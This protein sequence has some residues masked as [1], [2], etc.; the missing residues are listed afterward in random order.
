[1][2]GAMHTAMAAVAEADPDSINASKKLYNLSLQPIKE[3]NA[4]KTQIKLF[5]EANTLPYVE[6]GVRLLNRD[7]LQ[8][9]NE[10]MQELQGM[11]HE[12]AA[13]VQQWREPILQDAMTRLNKAYN[14]ANYPQDLSTLFSVEWSFPSVEPPSYLEK[15]CPALYE[16]EKQRV[17]ARFDEAVNLAEQAFLHELQQLVNTL[18]ERLTP[19]PDGKRKIIT[20]SAVQNLTDFFTKFQK[21]NLTNNQELET[22]VAEAKAAHRRRERRR[23]EK[24][25]RA[26]QRDRPG[27]EQAEREDH[28]P[29][30]Q[31]AAA[32]HPQAA[33]RRGPVTTPNGK[34]LPRQMGK[35]APSLESVTKSTRKLPNRAILYAGEGWGKTSFAAQ[36]P[37]AVFIM[38]R[39][40]DGLLKLM[41]NGIV[42]PTAHFPE[43]VNDWL[44]LKSC[45]HES[46]VKPHD[47]KMLVIDTVNG[48]SAFATSTSARRCTAATGA[49]KDS[50]VSARATKSPC[51]TGWSSSSCS[52]GCGTRA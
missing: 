36:A 49:R 45:L 32:K 44:D 19:G 22:L 27:P 18:H 12:L 5:V 39:G 35:N 26:P 4:L 33:E 40:E 50:C 20:E 29:C 30:R 1:M 51:P 8:E 46:I 38:T 9:F 25:R 43:C 14:P 28:P 6:P 52:T 13:T 10:R 7:S 34:P 15:L 37:R 11:L 17:Q 47:H 42:P 48:A 21:L 24:V 3:I 2:E 16:Q 23:P 31:Q 41:E